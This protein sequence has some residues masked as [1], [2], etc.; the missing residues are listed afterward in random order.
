MLILKL[1]IFQILTPPFLEKV[2]ILIFFYDGFPNTIHFGRIYPPF[3][4]KICPFFFKFGQFILKNG[5]LWRLNLKGVSHTLHFCWSYFLILVNVTNTKQ[6]WATYNVGPTWWGRRKPEE[7]SKMFK[8]GQNDKKQIHFSL[9]EIHLCIFTV[10]WKK[11]MKK[12]NVWTDRMLFSKVW[13]QKCGN[14]PKQSHF[15][16]DE[17]YRWTVTVTVAGT[18]HQLQVSLWFITTW[19]TSIPFYV[20]FNQFL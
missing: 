13:L 12:C 1:E 15:I 2:Y 6:V 9:K 4:I 3:L 10:G 20:I 8:N 19:Y 14:L 11:V 7:F 17:R 16:N 5:R 18:R